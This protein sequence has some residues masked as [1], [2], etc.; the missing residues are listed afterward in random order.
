MRDSIVSIPNLVLVGFPLSVEGIYL[1]NSQ[2]GILFVPNWEAHIQGLLKI[3][4]TLLMDKN[5][6][7]MA[8]LCRNM[9]TPL[10]KPLTFPKKE[11]GGLKGRLLHEEI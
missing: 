3:L 9:K 2:D 11:R 6:Q 4:L 10:L 8:S 1:H 5:L 7:F